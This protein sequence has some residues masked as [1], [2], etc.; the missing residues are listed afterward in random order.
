MQRPRCAA[1]GKLPS[2]SAGSAFGAWSLVFLATCT[3]YGKRSLHPDDALTAGSQ[4]ERRLSTP[5]CSNFVSTPLEM[6]GVRF[7]A[8]NDPLPFHEPSLCHFS[9]RMPLSLTLTGLFFAEIL[10]VAAKSL[11]PRI[12]SSMRFKIHVGLDY[13]SSQTSQDVFPFR[14]RNRRWT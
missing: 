8:H 2:Q 1:S 14:G 3:R 13:S 12:G 4:R 5:S 7:L 9:T 6:G 10:H 11:Q